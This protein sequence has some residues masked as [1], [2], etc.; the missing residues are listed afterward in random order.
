MWSPLLRSKLSHLSIRLP[1]RLSYR[2]VVSFAICWYRSQICPDVDVPTKYGLIYE[3]L[4]MRTEDGIT[5]RSYLLMQRKEISHTHAM[6]VDS[7][8]DQ[9]NEDVRPPQSLPCALIILIARYGL[10][11][12]DTADRDHV[13]WQWR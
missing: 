12:G 4:I 1:A 3:D 10:V 11:C 9:S 6:H 8:E 2:S 5:L 7:D 13:P